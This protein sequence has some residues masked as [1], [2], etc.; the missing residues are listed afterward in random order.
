MIEYLYRWNRPPPDH[1][2][3]YMAKKNIDDENG[4]D[5]QLLREK[6]ASKMHRKAYDIFENRIPVEYPA[7]T[8]FCDY[9]KSMPII[10]CC[11]KQS[12]MSRIFDKATTK[13]Y[14]ETDMISI[15]KT[16]RL[17]SF[18]LSF[19]T[20]PY[21]RALVRFFERYCVMEE[22]TIEDVQDM[23][24]EKINFP[25]TDDMLNSREP[26]LRELN[27]YRLAMIEANDQ[28]D[29]TDKNIE[30][31]DWYAAANAYIDFFQIGRE[32][33]PKKEPLDMF[34]LKNIFGVN[35]EE[36]DLPAAKRAF[37]KVLQERKD[38]MVEV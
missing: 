17:H 31:Q 26:D 10:R 13:L 14:A 11:C 30:F 21:Q 37:L 36:K 1:K 15:V 24:V 18:L 9:C 38:K 22:N 28:A 33:K 16:L 3:K 2:R 32:I 19:S 25:E 27:A 34:A 4:S 7:G 20:K 6:E 35:L 5:A 23:F 29:S 12:Q 8:A